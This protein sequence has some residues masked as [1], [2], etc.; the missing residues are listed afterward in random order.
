VA[1][2]FVDVPRSAFEDMFAASNAKL[3]AAGRSE[4]QRWEERE[5]HGELCFEITVLRDGPGLVKVVAFTSVAHGAGHARPVGRDAVRVAIV[6][7]DMH[8]RRW[9]VSSET[10]VLR[11][12]TVEGVLGRLQERLRLAWDEAR[13]L[14][15][16]PRCGAPAYADSGRC[17]VRPCRE[18]K[19]AWAS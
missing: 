6:F 15:R 5:Y 4:W 11:T 19:D 2:R 3:G 8:G 10:K 1:S 18:G 7:F 9:G 17:V 16:C 14:K 13:Q 12:G